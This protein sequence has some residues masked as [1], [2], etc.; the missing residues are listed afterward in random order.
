MEN[1]DLDFWAGLGI[2]FQ[3]CINFGAAFWHYLNP[4]I[5][6]DTGSGDHSR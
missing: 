3:E 2:H 1:V 4:K 5:C 6:D